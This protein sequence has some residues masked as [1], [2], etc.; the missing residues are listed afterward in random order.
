MILFKIIVTVLLIS[1]YCL[2]DNGE[3][4]TLFRYTDE[5]LEQEIRRRW[6][7]GPWQPEQAVSMLNLAVDIAT[8][9]NRPT[10]TRKFD[11]EAKQLLQILTDEEDPFVEPMTDVD[12]DDYLDDPL[13]VGSGYSPKLKTIQ[14]IVDMHDGSN[15]QRRRSAESIEKLYSW[16]RPNMLPR[17]KKRLQGGSRPEKLSTLRDSVLKL[18]KDARDKRQP[19][20]GR[21]IQKW[22]R[23]QA[24][25]IGLEDFSA[26]DS[27]LTKFKRRHGIVSRKV[28]IYTS[29]SEQENQQSISDSI[30]N[31]SIAYREASIPF[32]Q[33]Y[34]WNFDQTGFNYEPSNLRTLSFRG[35]RDTALE[36]NSRNKH[37]HSYSLQ[38]MISRDGKLFP[39]LLI[40]TQETDNHF[41]PKVGP[42]VKEL[43]EKYGNVEVY[44]TKSGKLTSAIVDQWYSSTLSRAV[45][46]VKNRRSIEDADESAVL[47]LADAWSGHSKTSQQNDLK[48][49]GVQML[50]IPP[51]TTD[52]LQ[53]LDVNFNRQLKI[54]Y[55]RIIEEAFYQDVLS[56]VT[57]REGIINIQ[58]LI[59]NQLSSPLYSDMIRYAWRNT[60]PSFNRSELQNFPPRMVNSI[61]FEFDDTAK[62]AK[63]S[64]DRHAFVRDTNTGKLFCFHHFLDRSFLNNSHASPNN[65]SQNRRQTRSTD[66]CHPEVCSDDSTEQDARVEKK[67]T[68]T[69]EAA[70]IVLGTAPLLFGLPSVISALGSLRSTP[71][72]VS[73]PQPSV[74]P[75]DDAEL[76]DLT[77]IL[78]QPDTPP[79][80]SSRSSSSTAKPTSKRPKKPRRKPGRR[81]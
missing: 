78:D 42:K 41:G 8:K 75:K 16:Y 53:P 65:S 24:A 30:K 34:I 79:T 50:R 52:R 39:K 2:G 29:R 67:F 48:R 44:P 62:C 57:S 71:K 73:T 31:F 28:T 14:M 3:D 61:Q 37:T 26:S 10:R 22:A 27:W 60:D 36:I 20:H 23:Q 74:E 47:I 9:P 70:Q 17:F 15:G 12:D 46:D 77:E 64:C 6:F 40:V 63:E 72:R 25:L 54:F 33:A 19:V 13:V 1:N 51:Q 7:G 35:E 21:M 68:P 58:S 66:T 80:Q 76:P 18:F 59:H 56:N 38:P 69:S 49:I 11:R 5:E 81:N 45:Q 43:E 55:N 32:D 4:E